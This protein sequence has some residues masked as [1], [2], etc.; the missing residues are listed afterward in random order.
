MINELSAYSK[1][2]AVQV[3]TPNQNPLFRSRDW[4]LSNQGPVFQ[5]RAVPGAAKSTY[6]HRIDQE[7]QEYFP[8]NFALAGPLLEG[9]PGTQSIVH[10]NSLDG[11]SH[12]AQEIVEIL[13]AHS[14]LGQLCYVP[15]D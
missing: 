14:R 3:R 6:I 15:G 8:R 11:D 4:L 1:N 12:H 13:V 5:Y 7:F 10:I 2:G 9:Q